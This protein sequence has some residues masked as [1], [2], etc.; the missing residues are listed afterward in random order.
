MAAWLS[1]NCPSLGEACWAPQEDLS[2]SLGTLS[3]ACSAPCLQWNQV[4]AWAKVGK[5]S[6]LLSHVVFKQILKR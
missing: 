1:H 2:F 4:A 6:I 5:V 3:P